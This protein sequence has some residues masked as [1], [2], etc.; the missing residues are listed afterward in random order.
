LPGYR[1]I[2]NVD[3]RLILGYFIPGKAF[4]P[5]ADNAFFANLEIRFNF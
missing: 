4:P 2:R 5:E 3:A 1:G